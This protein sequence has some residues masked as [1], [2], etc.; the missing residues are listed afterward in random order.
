M[1]KQYAVKNISLARAG[2]RSIHWATDEMPV[3]KILRAE[4][5]KTKPLAG[6]RVAACLHITK[7][8]GVLL[9]AL[10]AAGASVAACGSNPL[11][12]QD[13]V[14]ASLVKSGVS[15]FAWKGQKNK[16]YYQCLNRVLDSKPHITIDDGADLIFAI[17][18]NRPELL[19]TVRAGQ[20]ETTTGVIRLR[21]MST[22]G[23]LKYP[24]VA[25]NDTPTKHM[26]DNYYGTGQSTVDAIMR[27]TNILFAGKHIVVSG[28]G[29]CGSGI[30]LRAK[31]LGARVTVTEVDS[32]KA[33]QATMD[34][35]SVLPMETAARVGDVFIT[36]TG[37]RDVLRGPHFRAMKDGAILCNA[38][39]FNVEINLPEL[40]ALTKNITDVSEHVRE[41]AMKNAKKIFVLSEGRLVNLAAGEGHPSSVMDMSFANQALTAAWLAKNYKKLA[42]SIHEVPITID[43]RVA[44]LKLKTMGVA[45]DHL[46]LDQKRYLASW[47]EGT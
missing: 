22:A 27:A 45:I 34:G 20:E 8:T 47:Q 16:D 9:L 32:I 40:N 23:A 11:S 2:T 37:D 24:V 4:F 18:K 31:G 33:L 28:Y 25:V 30:A 3:M 26:F 13:A 6:V 17:H 29:H 7:E 38:G 46:T 19:K 14:A 41:Y 15:V 35:F 12:T 43:E 42:T 5:L 10:K 44:Q 21:A 36:A 39:H 1:D